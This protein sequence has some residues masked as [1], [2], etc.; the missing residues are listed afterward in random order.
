M[1]VCVIEMTDGDSAEFVFRGSRGDGENSTT[2]GKK[3]F[4]FGKTKYRSRKILIIPG[5]LGGN[6]GKIKTK[7]VEGEIPWMI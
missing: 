5:E 1:R 4:I 6:K 7:M 3:S 2:I